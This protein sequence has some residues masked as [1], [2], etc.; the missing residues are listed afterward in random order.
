VGVTLEEDKV[1]EL[2][3]RFNSHAATVLSESDLAPER[4]CDAELAVAELSDTSAAQILQLAP[5]G[6]G[7]RAPLF[8]VR[9]LEVR[10]PPELFGKEK[11][12][13]RVRLY[14]GTS[15]L[16]A[17]AWRFAERLGE[18]QPGMKIDAAVSIDADPFGAKRG[19]SPW[20]ATLRDIRVAE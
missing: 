4:A 2:R 13:V 3:A 20:G 16:F 18:L 12:H 15:F 8:L 10:Q 7:N 1:T 9:G 19:Y 14:Q 5:F 17:K 6:I 11:D